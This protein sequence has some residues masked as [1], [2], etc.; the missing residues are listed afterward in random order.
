M[1][2]FKVILHGI[3]AE[4][5]I[6]PLK[7][8]SNLFNTLM[9]RME[10]IN[11]DSPLLLSWQVG[12]GKTYAVVHGILP[13]AMET[14][15]KILYVSSRTA[16]NTQ[17]KREIINVSGQ[18]DLLRKLTPEGIRDYEDFG[19]IR[20]ITLQRLHSLMLTERNSLCDYG[21]LIFDEVHALIDDAMFVS[22]T[23]VLLEEIPSLFRN[24][25]RIY[26]TATPDAI[27]P[28]LTRAEHQLPIT[29]LKA[30][31]NYGYVNPYFFSEENQIINEINKDSSNK[32]WLVYLN[33]INASETFSKK[34]SC[35]Y[36]LLNAKVREDD[37]D[38]WDQILEEK[39]FEEKVCIVTAVV[40]AG[41]SFKDDSL[42][43]VV[44][45]SLLPDTI[46]QVLG[47][48]RRNRGSKEKVNM[49]V[50]CPSLKMLNRRLSENQEKQTIINS[51]SVSRAHFIRNYI[52]EPNKY[53]FRPLMY[54]YPDGNMIPNPMGIRYL[55][56]EADV[57]AEIL[58]YAQKNNDKYCFDRFI[59]KWLQIPAPDRKISWLDDEVNGV[60]RNKL[61]EFL[62]QNLNVEMN[63]DQ[64][65][66]FSGK[67]R[68]MCYA[69]Y[70]KGPNDR[71][72]RDFWKAVKITRKLKE[73][74]LPYAVKSIRKDTYILVSDSTS[75]AN[76]NDKEVTL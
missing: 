46:I 53:D 33:S 75:N 45:F 17:V 1:Q 69:A 41:V 35:S 19:A 43:N 70:G 27:L 5:E 13:W 7:R 67:F 54:V 71:S 44:I 31:R 56:Y 40:D 73:N 55:E 15:K 48:K 50:Y 63:E 29:V 64:F 61:I 49:Y 59:C 57:M 65:K 6:V 26:M 24:S 36:C 34:L 14:K 42:A 68:E 76:D 39:K 10:T 11:E 58:S 2:D 4:P 9:K 62:S 30:A 23:H 25:I 66:V 37:P 18:Q 52:L 72:D 22:C 8:G 38:L 20:V 60:G 16:I 3:T 21:I 28:R 12:A 47:R 74:R 32:K 51:Y